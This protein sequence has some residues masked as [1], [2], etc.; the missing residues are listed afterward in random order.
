MT[1]LTM[2]DTAATQALLETHLKTLRL[3]SFLQNHVQVAEEV[4]LAGLGFDRYLLAL[5]EQEVAQRDRNQQHRCIQSARFPM[6]KAEGPLG[7]S[8]TLTS[9]PCNRSTKRACWP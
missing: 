8:P 3:P 4:S 5:A 7:N 2:T 9:Q 1:S 6:L